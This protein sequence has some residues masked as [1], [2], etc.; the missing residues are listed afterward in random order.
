M[1][2]ILVAIDFDF[3][4]APAQHHVGDGSLA[5][6]SSLSFAKP[7]PA[8]PEKGICEWRIHSPRQMLVNRQISGLRCH[9]V[10][11]KSFCVAIRRRGL[12]VP[13][14]SIGSK[15]LKWVLNKKGVFRVEKEGERIIL[16]CSL[17]IVQYPARRAKNN[18]SSTLKV[19]RSAA[20]S[21]AA[22]WLANDLTETL[23]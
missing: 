14:P 1:N 11:P 13:I 16:N 15:R 6:T 20:A 22:A 17:L 8:F 2:K 12:F 23:Q 5:S 9:F 18:A 10:S 19:A 3:A 4:S 7:L 21:P